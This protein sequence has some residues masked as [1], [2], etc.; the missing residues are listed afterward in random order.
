MHHIFLRCGWRAFFFKCLAHGLVR[1]RVHIGQL[2]HALGEQA[3][4]PA[5]AFVGRRRA[6][7]RDQVGFLRAIELTFIEAL[8]TA[9]GA[10][11]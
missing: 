6:G 5:G 8:A 3:Q 7:E 9:V 11:C 10:E 2:H 1:E 4:R